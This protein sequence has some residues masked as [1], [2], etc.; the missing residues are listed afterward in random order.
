MLAGAGVDSAA[1]DSGNFGCRTAHNAE[2]FP[3]QL[4]TDGGRP[5]IE[6]R[7]TAGI[8]GV[9]RDHHESDSPLSAN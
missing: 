3:T 5:R 4:A 9:S 6:R 7:R 8:S 1:G 2:K